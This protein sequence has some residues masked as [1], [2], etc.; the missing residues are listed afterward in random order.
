MMS[1]A[2]PASI[3]YNYDTAGN[4][5]SVTDPEGNIT[6]YL[7]DD[8][9]NLV[10]ETSPDTGITHYRYDETGNLI[11]KKVNSDNPI[12]YDYD[13]LSRLTRVSYSDSTRDVT[14]TYDGGTNGK[15]RLTGITDPSGTYTYS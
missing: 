9:G 3:S 14:Y 8:A 12:L 5:V 2:S 6:T 11:S 10:K 1:G 13:A 7:Y 4:L 15:G